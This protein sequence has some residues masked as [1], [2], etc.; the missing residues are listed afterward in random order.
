MPKFITLEDGTHKRVCENC[1]FEEIE[2]IPESN[3]TCIV[4]CCKCKHE[5]VVLF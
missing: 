3:C 2:V 5:E 1:S 4:K